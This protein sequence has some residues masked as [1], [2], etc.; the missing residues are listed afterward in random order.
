MASSARAGEPAAGCTSRPNILII[1]LE[2]VR[3]DATSLHPS[4]ANETP[5]LKKLA[6]SSVNFTHAYSA[7]DFVTDGFFAILTGFK[8]G[9]QSPFDRIESALQYQLGQQGYR[10]FALLSNANLA[11]VPVR[12]SNGFD[13]RTN[14][15]D[16][17]AAMTPLEKYAF[18]QGADERLARYGAAK[19]E[20]NRFTLF[21]SPTEV[22]T[23]SLA[24]I[25]GKSPFFGVVNFTAADPWLPDPATYDTAG[26]PVPVPDL[27]ERELVPELANPNAIE[28]DVRRD[29]VLRTIARARGRVRTTSL[30]LTPQQ[31]ETYR[32]RYHGEVR[33][34]DRAIGALVEGLE[35][36][37]LLDSTI[38]VVTALNGQA[39]GERDLITNAFNS[40]GDIEATRR[41]PLLM[42]LPSCYGVANAVVDQP[43]ST[44]DIAPTLYALTAID[45]SQLWRGAQLALGRS[46]HSL[47]PD[48][49]PIRVPMQRAYAPPLTPFGLV[50]DR[51]IKVMDPRVRGETRQALIDYVWGS[52]GFPTDK[53]PGS[54]ERDVAVPERPA[55]LRR[56]DRINIA[57]TPT[58]EAPAYH[59][60]PV[61]PN[62]E[63]VLVLQGHTCEGLFSEATGFM[64][65][66]N[67]LLGRGYGVLG[68]EMPRQRPEDCN[69]AA[70]P[71]DE[72][73]ATLH[74][75]ATGFRFFFEPLA[76]SL[77]YIE[78]AASKETF[79]PYKKIH[80]FGFSGGGWTAG[81]FAA[82]DDRIK[83]TITVAGSIP[84]YLREGKS[85]GDVEQYDPGFYRLA[86]YP[87]LYVMGTL[88]KGR[89]QL[90]IFNRHDTCCF[91]ES[92]QGDSYEEDLR[93]YERDVR[94]ALSRLGSPEDAFAVTI[95]TSA[96]SHTVTSE[97]INDH[98]LPAL[99]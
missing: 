42:K 96:K 17:W 73:F 6:G 10:S 59:L 68:L 24:E 63:L 20:Y 56:A 57:L 23:R 60:L 67:S 8:R 54:V 16:V 44:A 80:L 43:A 41:V 65:L 87:D 69:R 48:L 89:R 95:D 15:S 11:S 21:K 26:E 34:I 84:L 37:K 72:L 47:L 85:M 88:G 22:L 18:I 62:G 19:S 7:S 70:Q 33:D 14:L 2:G 25:D 4:A 40:A 92:Q 49:R 82:L 94:A 55:A 66:I 75:G 3:A 46:L 98:I 30:D 61:K 83:N 77:N 52:D 71:H 12:T 13:K 78:R 38:I 36:R 74:E 39:F 51:E 29:F 58:L 97:T 81:V 31:L 35:K 45:A 53:M 64:E 28:D 90:Q 32:R 99:K 5:E 93:S 79:A 91:G 50:D 76:V 1:A 27:R 86:G 9:Y